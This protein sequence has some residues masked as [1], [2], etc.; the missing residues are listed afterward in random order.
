[1]SKVKVIRGFTNE[2]IKSNIKTN[3]KTNNNTN[4][5]TNSTNNRVAY[6]CNSM[7]LE[8]YLD[9]TA[10]RWN[11]ISYNTLK[12]QEFPVTTS[13]SPNLPWEVLSLH[14][15]GSLE[16]G[17]SFSNGHRWLVTH[18]LWVLWT[19]LI[20]TLVPTFE[21]KNLQVCTLLKVGTMF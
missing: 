3:I 14:F 19:I 21:T 12:L 9:A 7:Q 10:Y 20:L 1:M 18:L 13:W 8:Q 16:G 15:T 4:I 11:S 5:N 2:Y 17:F 6:I